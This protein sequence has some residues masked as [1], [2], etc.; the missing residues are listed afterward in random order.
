MWVFGYGS[1]VWYTNF[2][3]DKSVAGCLRGFARRFWQ[4]S[5]DHRGTH[6]KVIF[7]TVAYIY[8][9]HTG[10]FIRSTK[11]GLDM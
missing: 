5:P 9:K 6:E 7:F 2:P 10:R 8:Y 3:F 1:L 4:A 11:L